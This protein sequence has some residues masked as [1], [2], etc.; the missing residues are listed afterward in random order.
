[1]ASPEA[2]IMVGLATAGVVVALNTRGLPTN[3]DVRVGKVGDDTIETI[4]KQN[5]WMSF[6]VIGGL[7]LLTKDSLAF[8]MGGSMA[9]ALDWMTRAN[10]WTNPVENA[11]ATAHQ[12]NPFDA[13][14][15]S[16]ESAE[17]S[18]YDASLYAVS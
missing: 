11:I 10:N 13:Q 9:V 15:K 14:A 3:A 16:V 8:I 7:Y 4:R 18:A 12:I 5:L 2:R 6:G 1:M 17:A